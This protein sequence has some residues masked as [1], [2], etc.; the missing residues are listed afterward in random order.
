MYLWI[1]ASRFGMVAHVGYSVAGRSRGRVAPYSVCTVH[2][3]MRSKSFLVEPQHQGRWFINGLASKP[4]RRFSPVCSQNWWWQFLRFGLK[5][6]G[7]G[8]SG[9]ASKSVPTVSWLSLKT[10]VVESFPVW[11]SKPIVTVWWFGPQNHRD[12]FLVWTS[13][14]SRL[15]FVGC[16]IKPT[17]GGRHMTRVNI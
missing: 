17:E 10:N 14:P 6:D 5:T 4:L 7:D 3:E 8:F 11:T 16:A 12:G 13:K 15:R 1:L 2:M 9:L